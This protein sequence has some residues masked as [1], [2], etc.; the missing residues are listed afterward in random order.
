MHNKREADHAKL[1]SLLDAFIK[2]LGDSLELVVQRTR[3]CDGRLTVSLGACS[4]PTSIAEQNA[5][6]TQSS[7]VTSQ[8]NQWCQQYRWMSA[9]P[10]AEHHLMLAGAD[11]TMTNEVLNHLRNYRSGQKSARVMHL[12]QGPWKPYCRMSSSACARRSGTACGG[13]YGTLSGCCATL[14]T[15][16]PL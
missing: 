12:Q 15:C 7:Y 9:V 16:G 3:D 1:R 8:Q 14:Q 11:R 2:E 4:R 6:K 5:H 13:T 10:N